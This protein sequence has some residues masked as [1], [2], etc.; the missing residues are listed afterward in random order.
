VGKDNIPI[1][2][3]HLVEHNAGVMPAHQFCQFAFAL[4]D[5]HAPQIFAVEFDQ[6]ESNQHRRGYCD[7]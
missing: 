6:I 5:W 4:L 2:F 7:Q 1:A 3:E